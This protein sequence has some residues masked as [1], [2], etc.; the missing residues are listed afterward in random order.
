MEI[1]GGTLRVRHLL[2][3]ANSDDAF[4]YSQGWSGNAQF[5]IIQ[6]DS[7]DGDKGLEIDNAEPP[8]SLT[9]TPI[10]TGAAWNLTMIGKINAGGTTGSNA[11]NDVQDGI[12][13]R[14]GSQT[15]MH[16]MV[17]MGFPSIMDLDD[18]ATCTP[19]APA[20]D[21]VVAAN[22]VT[23]NNTDVEGTCGEE[24]AYFAASAS[25]TSVTGDGTSIIRVPYNV[26]AP[27]FRPVSAAAVA[28]G[29][30]PSGTGIDATAT[31]KGAVNPAN[32]V[33][34]WYLGWSRVWASATTP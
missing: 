30:T 19:S 24:A 6:Q 31:Y 34:P 7:A 11:N 13:L 15:P 22:F 27:D 3:T 12:N 5:V 18:D 25:N 33:I 4:D 17:M 2:S 29:V 10:T 9:L 23:I 32:G 28:G 8:Q 26:M 20:W 21:G 16:N 1:F 14:R